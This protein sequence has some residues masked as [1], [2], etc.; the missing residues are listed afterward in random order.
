MNVK[1]P[2]FLLSTLLLLA[3]CG[4]DKSSYSGSATSTQ[5]STPTTS[6]TQSQQ[7]SEPVVASE[8]AV[9]SEPAATSQQE[10]SSEESSVAPSSSQEAPAFDFA[11]YEQQYGTFTIDAGDVGSYTYDE[12]TRTYTLAVAESKAKYSLSGA[13]QGN[14]IIDNVNNLASYKGVEITFN[15]AAIA[16]LSTSKAAIQYK[17]DAKNV[18]IKAQKGTVNY[19]FNVG[20]ASGVYSK[21]NIEFSGKGKLI[22]ESYPGSSDTPHTFEAKGNI[23]LT[24]GIELTVNN[25]AHDAFHGKKLA[26]KDDEG[27][28][29]SGKVTVKDCAS[30]AFDFETSSGGGSITLD[31]G[32]FVVNG[33]DSVFKTDAALTIASGVTVTATSLKEEAVVAGDNSPGLVYT[34]NGTFTV[35]GQPY[36]YNA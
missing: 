33:A 30:Q 21:N 25:S 13:F 9:S 15:Q 17:L 20:E 7:T 16:S 8:P 6:Q 31:G 2:L 10:A 24:S 5:V 28:A 22:A 4:G 19:L 23:T 26:S 35:D 12:N 32:T 27:V 29:F 11:P 34:N 1:K 36:S 18:E 14:I 3:S